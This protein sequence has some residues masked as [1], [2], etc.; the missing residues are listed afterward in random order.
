MVHTASS[1]TPTINQSPA[2]EEET[3]RGYKS[4]D[5]YPVRI[6]DVF[7]DRYRIVTKL[8]YGSAST[9]WLCHDAHKEGEYVALKIYINRSKVH[10]EL[11][12]YTHINS[13]ASQHGGESHVRRLLDSF[14]LNGPHGKHI[15]LVHEA[16]GMTLDE[17]RYWIDGGRFAPAAIRETLRPILRAMHFLRNE[18]RIVHTDIQPLNILLGVLDHSRFAML[19]EDE[20]EHPL[21]RKELPTHTVY[22]SRP[23]RITHGESKLSDFS[24][25]RFDDSE[26]V[27]RVMPDVY[28]APEVVLG[29]P[30]SY[31]IDLWGFAMTLWDLFEPKRLFSPH[32][33]DGRYSEGHHLAQMISIMGPPPAEFLR[34][35]E[36]SL[37]F[38][39]EEGKWKGEIPVPDVT[40]EAVEQRLEG[41]EKRHFLTFMR[42]MLRWLPE[43]RDDLQEVFMDEWLLADLIET[44]KVVRD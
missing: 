32:G 25:A 44:G 30:W 3:V 24:E 34:R 39:D 22:T 13:L 8:G 23:M 12:I 10:R 28:R 19:E 6:G 27:D 38:W 2:I 15:C 4:Q 21:P 29:M 42:K 36:K 9:V 7:N 17:L 33:E 35:S 37:R 11:P 26:N 41:E 40:L 1:D 18:A 43:E 20:R 16:M 31:P 14:Q 5:Y